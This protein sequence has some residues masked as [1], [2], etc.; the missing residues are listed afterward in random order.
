MEDIFNVGDVIY[1][2]KLKKTNLWS[3]EQIPKANGAVV[4]MNPWRVEFLHYLGDLILT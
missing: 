3:L 2:K 4:V 1:V